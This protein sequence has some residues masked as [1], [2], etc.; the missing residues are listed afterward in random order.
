MKR[1][2][3]KIFFVMTISHTVLFCATTGKI[4]G[5]VTSTFDGLPL[6]GVNVIVEDT[7]FGAATDEKGQFVI[8]R[9]PSGTYTLRVEMIGYRPHVI[10]DVQVTTGL[11][12]NLDA[13]LIPGAISLEEI[14]VIAERPVVQQDLTSSTQYVDTKSIDQLPVVDAKDAVMF[15]SGVFFDPIPV[16]GGTRGYQ[17]ES[18]SGESRY[19][20]RGGDQD[21]VSWMIDGVRTESLTINK[22]DA[23]GSFTDVNVKA[24]KE[25]QV[26][27]GGFTAEYG[28]AQSGIVNMIMKEG[29]DRYEGSVEISY[30]P[31][32]QK[33]F[34]NYLY[35]YPYSEKYLNHVGY[36]SEIDSLW[37]LDYQ[38]E[39]PSDSIYQLHMDFIDSLDDKW[40]SSYS[41]EF[42]DHIDSTGTLD[43][44]W[45][46]EYRSKQVYDYR[47]IQSYNIFTTF[48][49]PLPFSSKNYTFFITSQF[50]KEVYTLPQP[51]D[52]RDMENV[53]LMLSFPLNP[54]MKVKLFGMYNHEV[55]GYRHLADFLMAS[56]YFRGYGSIN[57]TYTSLF[58]LQWNHALSDRMFYELKISRYWFVFKEE[59]PEYASISPGDDYELTLWGYYRY[60]DFPNENFDKYFFI[61]DTKE[62]TGDISITGNLNW[63]VNFQ[64][65][66]KAGFEYRYNTVAEKYNYRF[67]TLSIDRSEYMDRG[68]HETFHPI[69]FSTY[70]QDKMEFESMIL[71]FGVRYDYF[72]PNFDWFISHDTYNLAIDTL[73]NESLDIDGDQ[74]DSLGHMKYSFKNVLDKPRSPVPDHSMIS[75]RLGVS[76]PITINTVLHFN[77]GHFYQMPALNRMRLFRYFRP[78]YIVENIIKENDAAEEEGRDPEHIPSVA[79]DHE[80]IVLLTV[81]PLPPQKT[82]MFEVGLKHNFSNFVVMNLTAY[83]KDIYNQTDDPLGLFDKSFYG[84]DPFTE[85]TSTVITDTPL[86][87]DYG[88]SRGFEVNIKT[89]FSDK[90]VFSMNYSF[91]KAM[92][93]RASPHK[94]IF[95]ENGEPEYEWYT[96]GFKSIVI[97]RQFSRPHLLRANI[98]YRIPYN[99]KNALISDIRLSLLYRYTSGQSFTYLTEDDPSDT[100]DNYR[101]PGIHV[102]DLK[103]EKTV[104]FSGR[105]G[106]SIFLYVT[107]LFNQKNIKSMGDTIFNPVTMEKFVETG[108]PTTVDGGG[109]DIS[110]SIYYDPR[111]IMMGFSYDL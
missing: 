28:N 17:G 97:E 4:R 30:T 20:I 93:G 71:N 61:H 104:H 35:A 19:V 75:P 43:T 89:L 68:L 59:P 102:T 106:L 100:Y 90:F 101:Y 49:G 103:V 64:N 72:N 41:K 108:E 95:D 48:G 47:K 55:H 57:N 12:T 63:Q 26:L 8:L 36:L 42:R 21:E 87:G 45:W 51:R 91:S 14:V 81:E 10:K 110:W 88:D 13:V 6:V 69:Q 7:P 107:N 38:N 54:K 60:P 84:W 83:Y 105:S 44:L 33:H 86:P 31:P 58:T 40:W 98:F 23:G 99:N 62:E 70:L 80:R 73:Y 52:S 34:G 2:I 15:Q 111:K 77:Y 94:V 1:F 39:P 50:K 79:T 53:N 56:K 29:S 46:N 27:S 78:T 76:F 25:I 9:L 32:G 66:V 96:E 85:K 3:K 82:I 11:T 16:Q 5:K 74:V 92:H 109:Y 65:Q 22:R 18:G 67:T 37:W 24:V